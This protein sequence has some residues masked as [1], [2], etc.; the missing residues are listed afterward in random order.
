MTSADVVRLIRDGYI[1]GILGLPLTVDD[2]GLTREQLEA[3]YRNELAQRAV[4]V[5]QC[6]A[7]VASVTGGR[8]K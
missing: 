3:K 5:M 6:N 8:G 4:G 7:V 1:R 2:A